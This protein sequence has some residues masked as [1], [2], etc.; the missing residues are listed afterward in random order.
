MYECGHTS[1]QTRV[2]V[3]V[4]ASVYLCVDE[5]GWEVVYL[6]VYPRDCVFKCVSSVWCVITHLKFGALCLPVCV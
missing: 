2:A 4:A 6:S 3:S 5:L 1:L